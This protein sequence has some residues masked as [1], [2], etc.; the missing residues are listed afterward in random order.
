MQLEELAIV[1]CM[2]RL[3]AAVIGIG[4][5]GQ[6][7]VR[8]FSNFDDIELVA[9]ADIDKN[10]EMLAKKYNCKFYEDYKKMLEKEQLDFVSVA[11]PT[12]QHKEVSLSAIEKGLHV[13]VEKPIA[14]NLVDAEEIIKNAKSKGIKLM[15]GHV[16]RFNPAIKKIKAMVE[17][18][19]FGELISIEANRLSLYHPRIKD[20]GILVDLAVHDIDLLNYLVGKKMD[21]V[22][23]VATNK[24]MPNP[25]LEDNASIIIKFVN[26]VIGRINV[27]WTSPIKIREMNII[28]TKNICKT[29]TM[30]QKIELIENFL[31]VKNLVWS[32]FEEFLKTFEPKTKIIRGGTKE[33]L[34]I[35]L[36]EFVN[37]IKNN[38]E[39]PVI[40][41]DGLLAL[42]IALKAIESYK[43][44]NVIKLD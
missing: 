38:S 34:E 35:E 23:T 26:G 12:S 27:S 37:A 31:D 18:G 16:E 32:S 4:S 7:H 44:G 21:S 25:E 20:S 5:I 1:D 24:L 43:T 8:H 42:K 39:P 15:V 13:F 19:E 30:L 17:N 9:I 6:H 29:D 14:D 28:G 40:G 33:P 2:E 10:K 22:Y 3:K 41:E 36:R 11:V